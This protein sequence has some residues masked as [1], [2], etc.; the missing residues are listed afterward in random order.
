MLS[1]LRYLLTLTL[2]IL[3]SGSSSAFVIL[4]QTASY[5]EQNE[6]NESENFIDEAIPSSR[7][8]KQ[9]VK[10]SSPFLK[11]ATI[12]Q[13]SIFPSTHSSH[14]IGES[15]LFIKYRKLII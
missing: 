13:E 8:K 7:S 6:K 15:Y 11:A 5:T 1:P 10:N 4:N 9:V 3:L 12:K 2:V 14:S